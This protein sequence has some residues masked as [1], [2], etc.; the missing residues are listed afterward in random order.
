M[1]E[2]TRYFSYDAKCIPMSLTILGKLWIQ[3]GPF[4]CSFSEAKACV[5]DHAVKS[6]AGTQHLKRLITASE[7]LC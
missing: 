2:G 7:L 6:R 5:P 1:E 3:P 4:F